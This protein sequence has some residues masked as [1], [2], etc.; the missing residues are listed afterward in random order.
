MADLLHPARSP[1]LLDAVLARMP[2]LLWT[3]DTDLRCHFV[4]GTA[5]DR[6]ALSADQ[7][8]AASALAPAAEDERPHPGLEAHRQALSGES[9]CYELHVDGAVFQCLVEPL[10]DAAGIVVGVLGRAEEVAVARDPTARALEREI[11]EHRQANERLA[12]SERM[13]SD[14]ITHSPAVIYLKDLDGR[15]LLI[16]REYLPLPDLPA[17]EAARRDD[18]AY[19]GA[20]VA[21]IIRANDQRVLAAQT[22]MQ[23]EEVV[24][25]DGVDRTF[26]SIKFPLRDNQGTVYGICGISTDITERSRVEAELRRSEATLAAVIESSSDPICAIDRQFHIVAFNS[27]LKRYL[28][29]MFGKTPSIGSARGLAPP[30]ELV[31]RWTARFQRALTGERFAAEE[32][33][34]ID[35]P[36]HFLVSLNPTVQDGQV[37][38]VT[39]F[40]KDITELR[41]AEEQARHHQAELAHVLRLHTMG[42]LAASVA[43]EINQPLGAI[44]NYAQGARRRL[45]SGGGDPAELL[46]SVTE[47]ARE[48]LRAGEITRRVRELLRKE[49]SPHHDADLN[50]IVRA[51]VGIAESAARPSGVALYVVTTPDLPP[52][53]VDAI[54]IE[55]VVLNLV[56]NGIEATARSAARVVAVRT[57]ASGANAVEVSV[58]D[59]GAGID[60]SVAARIFEPFLTTKTNGLGMGLAISR[61]IVEAHGG[62]LWATSDAQSGTTFRFTLPA[63]RER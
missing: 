43:H 1:A 35:V 47:I 48:A 17:E 26:L 55:Q 59:S 16:N 36:R 44:A 62:R 61:S 31:E 7:L 56:L 9:G 12:R 54:Q 38:G 3:T 49:N 39:V 8:I 50:A 58:H 13:L 52:V 18:F 15:Y 6:L 5:A 19:F 25:H 37:T 42:E 57:N 11:V 22:S 20:A 28:Q 40:G 34:T 29:S 23:F 21:V 10:R 41:R 30:D 51:G 32:L 2:G 46:H 60:P 27:V 53:C 45:E 63:V 24:P 33:I 4:A 14:I